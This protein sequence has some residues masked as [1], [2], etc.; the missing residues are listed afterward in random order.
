[1][2]PTSVLSWRIIPLF[3]NRIS[4]GIRVSN[5]VSSCSR[6]RK[7]R[8]DGAK[9]ECFNCVK[10]ADPTAGTCSYDAAPRRRGKDRTPGSRR[11]APLEPKK[12]RTTR[13]RVEEEQRR[14]KAEAARA[15]SRPSAFAPHVPRDSPSHGPTTAG[16]TNYPGTEAEPSRLQPQALS[17][18]ATM[19]PLPTDYHVPPT[20]KHAQWQTVPAEPQVVTV[21]RPVRFN[22]NPAEFR[23][24]ELTFAAPDAIAIAR[25]VEEEEDLDEIESI[26]T[27]S[28]PPGVQFTRETWWDALLMTYSSLPPGTSMTADM[29]DT[30]TQIMISDLR[31]L[32][33]NAL[34]WFAF[35]NIPRFFARLWDPYHRQTVQP[36]LI[37]SAL[38]LAMFFQSSE[39]E[40]GTKGREKALQLIDHA[41]AMFD[42]SLSSG[43]IDIG[44]VQAAWVS[45]F[46]SSVCMHRIPKTMPMGLP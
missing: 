14:K 45:P 20:T 4:V 16:S 5:S 44:L 15:A 18:F 17:T 9:P 37:Y 22:F 23:D 26:S 35:V 46:F 30:T 21:T 34:H 28:T 2:Y 29:R 38:G 3:Y 33:Q 31:F 6:N 1:M 19:S 13:S 7:V 24:F 11:L 40:K 41:R 39:L 32:F 27:V 25:Q 8:C 12:T 42:A 10:R 43:W 36:S